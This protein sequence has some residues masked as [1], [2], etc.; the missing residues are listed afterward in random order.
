LEADGCNQFTAADAPVS[1]GQPVLDIKGFFGMFCRH[2]VLLLGC[3]MFSGERQAYL[4]SLI[5]IFLSVHAVTVTNLEYDI[6]PCQWLPAFV[7]FRQLA[8]DEHI[9]EAAKE[10]FRSC[11]AD[12]QS[13][14]MKFH[15]Y[16]HVA[17]CQAKFDGEQASPRP[18]P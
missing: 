6:G 11:L 5:W 10:L 13:P 4:I 14:L 18:P 7:T 15:F 17:R 9:S 12:L 16:C 2:G 8:G 3:H 1:T